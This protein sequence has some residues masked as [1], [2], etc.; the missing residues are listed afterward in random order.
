MYFFK[1]YFFGKFLHFYKRVNILFSWSVNIFKTVVGVDGRLFFS[2]KHAHFGPKPPAHITGVRR[3]KKPFG[4]SGRHVD[5]SR[6]SKSLSHVPCFSHH[7][8]FLS[9][10]PAPRLGF[11]RHQLRLAPGL[12]LLPRELAR[13]PTMTSNALGLLRDAL[14][15]ANPP[16]GSAARLSVACS[17]GRISPATRCHGRAAFTSSPRPRPPEFHLHH[18]RGPARAL[19]HLAASTAPLIAR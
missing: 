4:W 6:V 10:H 8:S 17:S 16:L 12:L 14:A 2:K 18:G 11:G 7:P 13:N 19:R 9:H 1:G 3:V 5:L 15:S